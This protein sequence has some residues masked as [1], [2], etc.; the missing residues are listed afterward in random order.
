MK[1]TNLTDI[2]KFHLIVMCYDAISQWT[3]DLEPNLKQGLKQTTKRVNFELK[4]MIKEF[5]RIL[6][7]SAELYGEDADALRW[8]IEELA[9]LSKS[10]QKRFAELVNLE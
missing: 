7:D 10:S 5:D 2:D 6:S 8:H 3:C 1:D 9:K 4:R